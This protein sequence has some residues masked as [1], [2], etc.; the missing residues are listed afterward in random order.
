MLT[1]GTKLSGDVAFLTVGG[2]PNTRF[3]NGLGILDANGAIKVSQERLPIAA[4]ISAKH[5]EGI[6]G[7]AMCGG[8]NVLEQLELT[9]GGQGHKFV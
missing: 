3:L 5:T 7:H 9:L 8:S 6:V 1:D 4:K 2:Q